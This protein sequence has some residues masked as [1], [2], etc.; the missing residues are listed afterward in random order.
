MGTSSGDF[1]VGPSPGGAVSR[2]RLCRTAEFTAGLPMASPNRTWW[3]QL[4]APEFVVAV[5][6]QSDCPCREITRESHRHVSTIPAR[7]TLSVRLGVRL[8]QGVKQKK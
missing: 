8:R 7:R 1:V 6:P 4:F 5:V 2:R 3:Q